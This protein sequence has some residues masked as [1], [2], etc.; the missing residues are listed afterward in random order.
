MR[1][2]A[3]DRVSVETDAPLHG[4]D[5]LDGVHDVKA[6]GATT[7]FTMDNSQT[8]RLLAFLADKGVRRFTSTPPT[9]EELF[10]SHYARQEAHQ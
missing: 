3:R 8:G 7:T 6:D 5:L 9:L 4:L 1:H 10:M 2:L